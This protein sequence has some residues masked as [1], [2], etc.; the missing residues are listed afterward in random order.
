MELPCDDSRLHLALCT[1]KRARS[2]TYG[3]GKVAIIFDHA[4]TMAIAILGPE[5]IVAWAASQ[6]VV[7]WRV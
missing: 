4:K 3:K 6:F 1:S 7:A 5:V 2:R